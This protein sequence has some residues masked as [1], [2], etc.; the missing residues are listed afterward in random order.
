MNIGPSFRIDLKSIL[1]GTAVCGLAFVLIGAGSA[2]SP[3][4]YQVSSSLVGV[5]ICDTATGDVKFICHSDHSI[6][7][8]GYTVMAYQFDDLDQA[9]FG[10]LSLDRRSHP[11]PPR[12]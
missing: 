3:G 1:I 12:P 4:R 5:Y 6:P 10:G 8:G 7:E 11:R 9:K 2:P